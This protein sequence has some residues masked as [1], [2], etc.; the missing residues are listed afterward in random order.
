MTKTYEVTFPQ[1]ALPGVFA[2]GTIRRGQSAEVSAAAAVRLVD[3]KGLAFANPDDEH[4]AR[5]EIAAPFGAGAIEITA[6]AAAA[7]ADHEE[8]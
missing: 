1:D 5:A 6:P 2:V 7:A 4:A 3:V 8:H